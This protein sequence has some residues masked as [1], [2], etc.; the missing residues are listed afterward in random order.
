VRSDQTQAL[1][2]T[3]EEML[4]QVERLSRQ[5][6]ALRAELDQSQKLAM[7]GT[8]AAMVAHEVN[9]LMTP[10]ATYAQMALENP[11]D[12]AIVQKALSR[13]SA[14]A[15]QASRI[16]TSILALAKPGVGERRECDVAV[17]V[18]DALACVPRGTLRGIQVET[19]LA[20]GIRAA[21]SGAALQQVVLNLLLNAVRAVGGKSGRISVRSRAEVGAV[22]VE[23][24]DDGPGVDASVASVVFQPFASCASG[25]G[26]GLAICERL[27]GEVGGRIWLDNPGGLGA[28]FCVR[29]PRVLATAA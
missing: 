25:T 7:L 12:A 8:V 3:P 15:Q 4:A 6:D 2:G 17:A 27:V 28:R 26:L 23:V 1:R 18:A 14:G 24:E 13:A 16:A 9:N 10:I 5:L 19:Q 11:T 20:P 21:M 22:L 29:L